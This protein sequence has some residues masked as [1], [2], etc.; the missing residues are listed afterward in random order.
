M[1][2]T[3]GLALLGLYALVFLP[4]LRAARAGERSPLRGNRGIET[5]LL[6]HIILLVV[7][8]ALVIDGF[9]L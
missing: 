4:L 3:I 2:S 7:G 1:E 5:A 8:V 6:I 9:F